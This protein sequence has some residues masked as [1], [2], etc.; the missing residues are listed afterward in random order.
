MAGLSKR[1]KP[2]PDWLNALRATMTAALY[3]R[4]GRTARVRA[5]RP[6][7]YSRGCERPDGGGED[8]LTDAPL[9]LGC[10]P[11]RRGRPPRLR[12]QHLLCRRHLRCKRYP[13]VACAQ[14]A[15]VQWSRLD[16][17]ARLGLRIGVP[18]AMF[19]VSRQ[20]ASGRECR[21]ARRRVAPLPDRAAARG[22][23]SRRVIARERTAGAA[24]PSSR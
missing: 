1:S 2:G 10:S 21:S 7:R 9:H 13:R 5:D 11:R 17:G 19:A 24:H 22:D 14:T 15:L 3:R 18:R 20:T 6:S 23:Q 8:G 12:S 4:I 16:R